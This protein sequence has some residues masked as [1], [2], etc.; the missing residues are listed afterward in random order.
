[1]KKMCLLGAMFIFFG[2]SPVRVEKIEV[3]ASNDPLHEPRQILERYAAG[4]ALGSEVTSFPNL[5]DNVRK[6]DATRGDVL[7]KGLNDRKSLAV[8]PRRQACW[9]LQPAM[10]TIRRRARCIN[11][12]CRLRSVWSCAVRLTRWQSDRIP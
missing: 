6:V 2:C 4:Q 12:A 7:D 3:K 5:V 11:R 10:R 9:R 1:M 8:R